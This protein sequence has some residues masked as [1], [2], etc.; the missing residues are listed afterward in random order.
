M[1]RKAKKKTRKTDVTYNTTGPQGPRS[2][3]THSRNSF[4]Y[5]PIKKCTCQY[6][7]SYSGKHLKVSNHAMANVNG[8]WM[9]CLPVLAYH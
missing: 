5:Y 8:N 1:K 2:S 9:T 6:H 7:M 3:L 4:R